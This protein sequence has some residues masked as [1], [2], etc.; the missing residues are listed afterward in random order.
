MRLVVE[1]NK[2]KKIYFIHDKYEDFISGKIDF[3]DG[4]L[5]NQSDL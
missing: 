4:L 3:D 2:D 5:I 1:Q